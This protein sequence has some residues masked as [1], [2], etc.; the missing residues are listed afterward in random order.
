MAMT[1]QAILAA[2]GK[3]VDELTGKD[4]VSTRQI[5][6]VR[7]SGADVAFDVEMSYPARSRW[8]GLGLSLIH[9]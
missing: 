9:I 1:E 7:F 4:F 3:V 5:K 6:N 2:L 8:P